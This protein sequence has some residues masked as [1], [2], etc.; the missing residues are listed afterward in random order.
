MEAV[1]T[2]SILLIIMPVITETYLFIQKKINQIQ[3]QM[4]TETELDYITQYIRSDLRKI[5]TIR[6]CFNSN[7]YFKN[8]NNESIEYSIKNDHIRRKKNSINTFY[9]SDKIAVYSFKPVI[10]NKLI[11]LKLDTSLGTEEI[12]VYLPGLK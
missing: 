11:T 8:I 3:V 9:I 4:L 6:D 12:C 7:L 2:T 1:I 5:A 10:T